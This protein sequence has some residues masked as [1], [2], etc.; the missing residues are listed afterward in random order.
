VAHLNF[1]GCVAYTH[2]PDELRRKLDNKG[3]KC[4]FVGHSK[5]T[6]VYKLYDPIARKVIINRDV[7]FVENE[8]WDGSIAMTIKIIDAMGDDETKEEEEVV[9]TPCTSQCA[10]PSTSGTAMQITAQCALVRTK[11]VQ[12]TPRAQ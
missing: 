11:G 6:K 2:V 10:V 1:F 7:Q 9:Q 8:A 5:E 3:H 4:I 12:S